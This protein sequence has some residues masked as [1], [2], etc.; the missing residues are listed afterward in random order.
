MNHLQLLAW[1]LESDGLTHTCNMAGWQVTD[2]VGEDMSYCLRMWNGGICNASVLSCK[3]VFM[4][5]TC[6]GPISFMF[7]TNVWRICCYVNMSDGDVLF[8]LRNA[9]ADGS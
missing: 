8:V 7:E 4:Q 6:E 9:S 2:L 3:M 5:C 1:L